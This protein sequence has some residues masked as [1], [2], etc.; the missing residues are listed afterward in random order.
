MFK[1]VIAFRLASFDLSAEDLEEKLKDSAKKP[2]GPQEMSRMGFTS[3]FGRQSDMLVHAANGCYLMCLSKEEKI[4]P[5][6]VVKELLE[7]KMEAIEHEQDRKVRG[8]EKAELKEQIILEMLPQ[9]FSKT[10]KTFGYV[11][12]TNMMLVVDAG[13][14]KKAEDF[15]SFIRK[16]IGSLKAR[17]IAVEQ[18]PGFVMTSWLKETVDVPEEFVVGGEAS[19]VD[20]GE[21][22]GTINV[23]NI[24]LVSEEIQNHL[25]N[26]MMVKQMGVSFDNKLSCVLTDEVQIKKIKFGEEVNEKIDETDAE[27]QMARMDATFTIVSETIAETV[28]AVIKAFGGELKADEESSDS[29]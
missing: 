22:G 9:A 19:L 5:G 1:N 13:S 12:T 24:E 16:A 26:G 6:P 15:G 2:L 27:D 8:K 11:D 21:D 25:D 10:S 14:F 18:N 17:P 29:E 28:A 20:P 7:E 4:I 3:P 23:K